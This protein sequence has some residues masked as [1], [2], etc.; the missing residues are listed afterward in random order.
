[1]GKVVIQYPD[2]PSPVEAG[3]PGNWEDWSARPVMYGLSTTVLPSY[4]MYSDLADSTI[5]SG[6]RPYALYSEPGGDSRLYRFKSHADAYTV[7]DEFDP[8]Q[9]ERY[10]ANVTIVERQKA[11]NAL[12]DADYAIGTQV[13]SGTYANRY[14]TEI[15]VPGGKFWGVE[16]GNRGTFVLDGVQQDRNRNLISRFSSACYDIYEDQPPFEWD[17]RRSGGMSGAGGTSGNHNIN[18]GTTLPTGPDN[19]PTNLSVRFWRRVPD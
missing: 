4:S 16:G 11:G 8:V 7:P 17:Q 5:A 18:L 1:V 13:A 12:T 14:V 19:A 2:E 9:W 3:Y 10:S 6:S 15:I